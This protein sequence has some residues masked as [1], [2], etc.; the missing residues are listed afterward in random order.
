MAASLPPAMEPLW[1]PDQWAV[2]LPGPVPELL[3]S[4][5]ASRSGQPCILG[6]LGVTPLSGTTSGT[7]GLSPGS[8]A[9]GT[10][11]ESLGANIRLGR[12]APKE[13]G[14]GRRGVGP[15]QGC[16]GVT[17]G[18]GRGRNGRAG[19]FPRCLPPVICPG[20]WPR[21]PLQQLVHRCLSASQCSRGREGQCGSVTVGAA[22]AIAGWLQ[23]GMQCE[24]SLPANTSRAVPSGPPPPVHSSMLPLASPEGLT[25]LPIRAGG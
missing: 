10:Q 17:P 5:A 25:P 3:L 1:P 9:K 18:G 20:R 22:Q 13:L 23:A 12:V 24:P 21:L 15:Q 14:W 6:S 4:R 19:P 8:L 2:R 7:D 11:G 16:G